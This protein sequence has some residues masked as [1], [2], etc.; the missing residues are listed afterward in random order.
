MTIWNEKGC[1]GGSSKKASSEP[2][3]AP[4]PA[5]VP[6]PTSVAPVATASDR[7]KVLKNYQYGLA[8]TIKTS[9]GGITGSGPELRAPGITGV[10]KTGQS[11]GVI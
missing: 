2:V 11:A 8:S 10:N 3:A 6:T 7:A 1:F 4:S 5:P 9:S